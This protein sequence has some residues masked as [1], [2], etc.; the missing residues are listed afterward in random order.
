LA[1]DVAASKAPARVVEAKLPAGEAVLSHQVGG[2]LSGV[3]GMHERMLRFSA[4]ASKSNRRGVV[5]LIRAV[6]NEASA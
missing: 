1:C 5:I 2:Q 3:V 6:I 4:S